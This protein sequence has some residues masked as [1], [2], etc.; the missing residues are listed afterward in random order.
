MPLQSLLLNYVQFVYFNLFINTT[1]I[2]YMESAI[3]KR[4]HTC[5][6][7]PKGWLFRTEIYNLPWTCRL[8]FKKFAKLRHG[9]WNYF[10]TVCSLLEI[11]H[12][13]IIMR[14]N[15]YISFW[16][17]HKHNIPFGFFSVLIIT[18]ITNNKNMSKIC[19]FR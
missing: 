18:I 16:F 19:V 3:I 14:F 1:S 4:V 10:M 13:I 7:Y 5:Y 8:C 15:F 17:T 11:S 12:W 2:Y 9:Q 6:Y